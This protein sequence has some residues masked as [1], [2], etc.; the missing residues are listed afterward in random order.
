MWYLG[1]VPGQVPGQA[2]CQVPGQIPGLHTLAGAWRRE[3]IHLSE[4]ERSKKNGR[5][6]AVENIRPETYGR[7]VRS[8]TSCRKRLRSETEWPKAAAVENRVTNTILD[9]EHPLTTSLKRH[10]DSTALQAGSC[11][12]AERN[13]IKENWQQS[14]V[15]HIVETNEH[16]YDQSCI[17]TSGQYY[18]Q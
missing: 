17:K 9:R 15:Q 3:K 7:N 8:K 18:F 6:H 1:K 2:P 16:R 10:A 12:P 11:Q 5:K 4:I 14:C 13:G